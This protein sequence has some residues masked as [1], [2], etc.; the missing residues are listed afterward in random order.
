MKYGLWIVLFLL[1]CSQKNPQHWW[2]K[3]DDSQKPSWEISPDQARK[4]EVILSKRNELGAFSN[5]SHTPF[6]LDGMTYTSIEGFWQMMKYPDSK[7]RGDIRGK[8]KYPYTRLEVSQMYGFQAKKAGDLAN[9]I[10]PV[11]V[12]YQGDKFNYKDEGQGQAYHYQLIERATRAKINQH[13][14]LKELLIKT[15]SLEL[16]PDHPQGDKPPRSYQYYKIL[17]KIRSEFLLK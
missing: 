6:Y 12:S 13:P 8:K 11:W 4:G 17:M 1:S 7:L 5:F 3:I 16:K 14:N 15:D 10:G 9:K 2:K